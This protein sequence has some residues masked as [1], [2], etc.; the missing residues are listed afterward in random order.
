MSGYYICYQSSESIYAGAMPTPYGATFWVLQYLKSY[1]GFGILMSILNNFHLSAYCDADWT[2]C[3]TTCRSIIGYCSFLGD[4]FIIWHKKKIKYH[5]SLTTEAEYW[6]MASIIYK[7]RWLKTLLFD[8][9][10]TILDLY[11]S[12]LWYSSCSSYYCQSCIP[13]VDKTR[14]NWLSCCL[15]KIISRHNPDSVFL[16]WPPAC[17][18]FY[19]DFRSWSIFLSIWQVGC[20]RFT[21]TQLRESIKVVGILSIIES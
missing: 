6:S 16:K 9:L 10:S 5:L 21:L 13:W 11:L 4:C 3:S 2:S 17:R 7:L 20:D 8:W 18:Y 1:S 12:Q 14:R 15:K 19:Q